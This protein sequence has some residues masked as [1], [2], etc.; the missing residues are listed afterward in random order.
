MILV[1]AMKN[2]LN[3]K[4]TWMI[5]L[6]NYIVGAIWFVFGLVYLFKDSFMPYHAV[7]ISSSWEELNPAF[8]TL[9]LALM[10]AA[11]GG[12]FLAGLMII[13]LQTIYY[14][15]KI[16][17]IP[18]LILLIGVIIVSTTV[19]AT[20][21]VRLNTNANPPTLMSVASLLGLIIGYG[22]NNYYNNDIK[23]ESPNR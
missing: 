23:E 9:I 20:L 1:N 6:P 10:R 4:H 11:G 22:M 16:K 12:F 15:T 5:P 19:Y 17:W 14:R 18:T 7:A 13:I 8:Q 21:I 3:R 2:I